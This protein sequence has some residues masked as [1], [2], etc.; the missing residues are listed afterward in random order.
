MATW[1]PFGGV[2]MQNRRYI[3]PLKIRKK[4]LLDLHLDLI[5]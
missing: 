5:Q 1:K 2:P 4:A 3:L